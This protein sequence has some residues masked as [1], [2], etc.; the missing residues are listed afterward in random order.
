MKDDKK[1]LATVIVAKIG[2]KDK[3][4]EMPEREGAEMES[5]NLDLIADEIMSAFEKKDVKALKE[6]LLA[7]IESKDEYEDESEE[8]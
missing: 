5:D 8:A 6:S 4:K 3:E 2:N 1:K 7:F